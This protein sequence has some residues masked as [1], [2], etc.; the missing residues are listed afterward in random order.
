MASCDRLAACPH[1]FLTF[2]YKY[3]MEKR[4]SPAG[5]D[6]A[7]QVWNAY[8]YMFGI[9]TRFGCCYVGLSYHEGCMWTY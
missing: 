6:Y 7:R 2:N 9:E 8:D 1:C 5:T 3:T 4:Q